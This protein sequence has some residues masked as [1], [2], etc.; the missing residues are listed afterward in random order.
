MR[1]VATAGMRNPASIRLDVVD[2]LLGAPDDLPAWRVADM[3]SRGRILATWLSTVEARGGPLGPQPRAYLRR[4]RRRTADLHALGAELS[5]AYGLRVLKGERIARHLPEPLLRQSGDVDLVAPDE[6]SLWRCVLDLK[7][8]FEAA[9]EGVSVLDGGAGAIHLMVAV[10][11]A[12]SEP[13]LDKPMG[14]DVTT[15]AFGGDFRTVPLRATPPEDDDLANLLAVAEERFQRKFRVKDHLDLLTLA[16]VLERRFGDDVVIMVRD[17]AAAFAL[18]PELRR[19]IG[20][21]HRWI[22]LS[23]R[24]RRVLDALG[25]LAREEKARRRAGR[26]GVHRLR[27]GYPLDGPA[28]AEATVRIHPR[29]SGDVAS[30]PAG[31]CLLTERLVVDEEH[32]ATAVE[33]V[34]SLSGNPV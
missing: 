14:V 20:G 31:P 17:S 10:K 24:W 28:G 26:P 13:L 21:T 23:A 1:A 2:R 8:R 7:S 11:W 27:F 19:L 15:F 12:A 5:A 30:T 25:P 32:L 34:R 4:V 29:E 33:F 16:D 22:P 18:A 6:V 9:I 3:A